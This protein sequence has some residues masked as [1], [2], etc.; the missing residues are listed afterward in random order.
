MKRLWLLSVV[1]L[2]GCLPAWG[3]AAEG[4][5]VFV[6]GHSFH[7]FI[8][9][10]LEALAH[11]AGHSGHHNAGTLVLGGSR[12]IDIWNLTDAKNTAKGALRAGAVDVFTLS[13]NKQIPDPGIDFYT[14]LAVKYNPAVR[15]LL[16][17]S[18]SQAMMEK[19]DTAYWRKLGADYE[20]QLKKQVESINA[21]H[22]RAIVSIVPVAPALLILWDRIEEGEI[23]GVDKVGA[24]FSDDAL[25]PSP[26]LQ[27]LIVY[28]WFASIY[29]ESPVGLKS[30]D[31][32][33]PA[34]TNRIL[35]QLAWD[36]VTTCAKGPDK[37]SPDKQAL[38]P[39]GIW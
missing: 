4:C 1:L 16:Q 34:A 3:G 26:I 11:E 28:C 35:Q 38:S 6:C 32:K 12:S 33:V 22:G 20:A 27:N 37:A 19:P 2:V 8:G 29:H 39:F 9:Q 23:P 5:R 30:L 10:P 21:R 18:W 14:D 31:G 24:L 13:P 15:V 25:H 36:T 17:F 7:F